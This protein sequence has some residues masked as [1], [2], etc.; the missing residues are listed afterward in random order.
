MNTGQGSVRGDGL[1]GASADA[2][3][4]IYGLEGC[5]RCVPDQVATGGQ[6]ARRPHLGFSTRHSWPIRPDKE[7][8]G[9]SS[10]SRPTQV[11][12]LPP[13]QTPGMS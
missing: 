13:G 2:D 7:E 12:G 5:T 9:S 3:A 8:V 11:S 1:F 6:A 10:L 4:G